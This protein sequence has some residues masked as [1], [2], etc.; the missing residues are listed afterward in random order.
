M[1]VQSDEKEDEMENGLS[2][3]VNEL[4]LNLSRC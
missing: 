3:E 4:K 2:K 1:G